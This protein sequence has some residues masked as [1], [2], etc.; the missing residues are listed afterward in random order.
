MNL[1]ELYI[2]SSE[3]AKTLSDKKLKKIKLAF[4][5]IFENSYYHFLKEEV[6]D[7]LDEDE[8]ELL[9]ISGTVI[10]EE[11]RRREMIVSLNK[12]MV[13]TTS[14]IQEFHKEMKKNKNQK[15]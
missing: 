8:C 5:S 11:I 6:K 2:T 7:K 13:E 9:S 14:I 15:K 1:L 4:D 3:N 12:S 10:K